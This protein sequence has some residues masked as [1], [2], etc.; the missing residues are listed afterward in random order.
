MTRWSHLELRERSMVE[1]AGDLRT[2]TGRLE[3]GAGSARP[4]ALHPIDLFWRE[5]GSGA[6]ITHQGVLARS[7]TTIT[8][9]VVVAPSS[10][11][12]SCRLVAAV[13]G[14]LTYGAAVV[15]GSPS[16]IPPGGVDDATWGGVRIPVV[17]DLPAA[18]LPGDSHTLALE[19]TGVGL[20]GVL[21]A[22]QR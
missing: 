9:L 17:M 20:V 3:N 1:V 13:N 10:G 16:P 22:W 8:C 7:G 15:A 6:A 5:T 18:W 19:V 14:V 21:S 2:R 11:T 12:M 4:V